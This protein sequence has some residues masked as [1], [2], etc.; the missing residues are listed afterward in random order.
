MSYIIFAE[1]YFYAIRKKENKKGFLF[2]KII[3]NIKSTY[4]PVLEY[5][6]ICI[7]YLVIIIFFDGFGYVSY[8]SDICYYSL[9]IYNGIV[10]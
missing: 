3:K 4:Q 5:L 10:K 7:C 9:D 1:T 6:L 2:P 8:A